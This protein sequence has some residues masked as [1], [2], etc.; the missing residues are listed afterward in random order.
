MMDY[1][2][3]TSISHPS[4][5]LNTTSKPDH[6]YGP[7]SIDMIMKKKEFSFLI[8]YYNLLYQSL[9]PNC[10]LTIKILK[11]HL[12]ISGD[13]ESF[14]VNGESSRIRCQRIINLL[15]VQLDTTRDCKHFCYL[16]NMISVTT[17]LPDKLK[18]EFHHGSYQDDDI[19]Q[20]HYH[21]SHNTGTDGVY[22]HHTRPIKTNSVNQSDNAA[23]D[24]IIIQCFD[25]RQ[26]DDRTDDCA[27]SSHHQVFGRRRCRAANTNSVEKQ[28]M[29]MPSRIKSSVD[30][31]CLMKLSE[32]TTTLDQ[33]FSLLCNCLP[34]DYQS[35]LVK[36]KRLSQLSNDDHQQF[37]TMISS[38]PCEAQL[39]NEKIVTFLIVIFCYNGRSGSQRR[40]CD[41]IDN[42]IESDH[43]GK[44]EQHVKCAFSS[45]QSMAEES[46]PPETIVHNKD[47]TQ[48]KTHYHT[49][50]QLMPDN[51]EQSVGKLQN[52]ISDDQIC[53]ILSSSNSTAA[54]KKILDCLIERMSCK[55]ELLDLCDQLETITTSHQ[56][57]MV[58]SEMRSVSTPSTT[59]TQSLSSYQERPSVSPSL[60]FSFYQIAF[61]K[62][63]L[64]PSSRVLPVLK[65]HYSRLY[66]C[67]P[68]DF[69]KTVD[70]LM[71]LLGG[72]FDNH[73]HTLRQLTSTDLINERIV[74]DLICRIY[75]EDGALTFC[76]IM[77]SICDAS[78]KDFIETV[79]N[80]V[81]E[82]LCSF[83][84]TTTTTCVSLPSNG[85]SSSSGSHHP[86][87]LHQTS[88][89]SSVRVGSTAVVSSGKTSQTRKG[90]VSPK[91]ELQEQLIYEHR[92][93][94]KG[95][96]CPPPPPLPPNYVPRQLV[97]NEIVAKICHSTI[98]P[99]S[100]GTSLT[101]SGAGGFGKT[102]TVIALCHHSVIK[103]QF[104]DGFV[105]IELG[106]QATDPSMKLSQLYHL[107]TGK[108]LKQGDINHAE[109]EINQLTSNC[110]RNLLV[111]IDDVWHVEDA[112][113]IVK[114]FSSCKIVLTTR[115]NDIVRYIPTKQ[116]VGV[117][118]ME[119]NE[120][121][122]LLTCGVI[123]ISQLSQ[124]DVSLLDE[125]A[126]DV[127]LWPLL[128]SLIRGQLSHNLN[129]C[130]LSYYE[131]IQNVRARLHGRG[132]SAFD[133]NNIERS[134][135]YAVKVCIEVTFDLL[136]KTQTDKMKML[137]LWTGIGVSQQTALLPNLWKVTEQEATDIV[138][139]LWA[140]GLVQ[141]TKFK[142]P[143]HKQCV[144]VHAVISQYVT[145]NIDSDEVMTLSPYHSY[146]SVRDKS[147]Q[148]ILHSYGVDDVNS[149]P[150]MDFVKYQKNALENCYLPLYLKMINSYITTDPHD[151]IIVLRQIKSKLII[152]P[153]NAIFSKLCNQ[154]D[155]LIRDCHKIL[156]DAYKLSRKLNQSVQRCLT[157]NNYHNFIQTIDRHIRSYPIGLLAQQA[158]VMV[159]EVMP[160]C[161]EILVY[162]LLNDI[163]DLYLLTPDYHLMALSTLPHIEL[164]IKE[165]KQIDTALRSG[166]RKIQLVHHYYLS[167]KCYEESHMVDVNRFI[168]LQPVV[169]NYVRYR[170]SQDGL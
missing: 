139:V 83:S 70:K 84:P 18:T 159:K 164:L 19:I 117:G 126:Q 26:S 167:G 153:N 98:D 119:Q 10:K 140:Y 61:S 104:T 2:P 69:E 132:L 110:C 71:P 91:L 134:R 34:D 81:L 155:S 7:K 115:M 135:K 60:N 57:T 157:E 94:E 8:R 108:Y 41:L 35:T 29:T 87:T 116:V 54:N 137:I 99:N 142:I 168:T 79:R 55:E 141:F 160:Y 31:S 101:V 125:L 169:P 92:R 162:I 48:L 47:F 148:L 36:L 28:N 138:D 152:S 73:L 165:L 82:A 112:E 147:K 113:P 105:F 85:I 170:T 27:N 43:L 103:E 146:D 86:K 25:D 131:S 111:V 32:W 45:Q 12:Q 136:T 156:R 65:K 9:M 42:L 97:L 80:E 38:S 24:N 15:L 154:I 46:N 67:L 114:A 150:A 75:E 23:V 102:S 163:E 151:A 78:S 144:E 74:S 62:I 133:K 56:L 50:L 6:L 166:P 90:H 106:P 17:D 107:L 66:Y 20:N 130:K 33:C 51:Y 3:Y 64:D 124:E 59:N 1:Y 72:S 5:H 52:Y 100:Y 13:V 40:L 123:N 37:G 39:V 93:L 95:I 44:C 49:I 96:K 53:M 143:P 14:I 89:D 63:E 30:L 21:T 68:Q 118:P 88:N 120:A 76:D 16:F 58:I 122:S 127:H 129:T 11:Q 158:L 128:L 121:I 22:T 145:E 161:D 77:D 4:N 109:Q 149:L